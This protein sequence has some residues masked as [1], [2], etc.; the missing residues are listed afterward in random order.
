MLVVKIDTT[1]T[2]YSKLIKLE[3]SLSNT[4]KALEAKNSD[5]NHLMEK[6]DKLEKLVDGIQLLILF[7]SPSK[8]F[9]IMTLTQGGFLCSF[10]KAEGVC[11]PWLQAETKVVTIFGKFFFFLSF[12]AAI[13]NPKRGC[14]RV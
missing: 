2:T 13:K 8:L 14:R 12:S 10:V 9:Y 4:E 5:I 11:C 1:G 3:N 7:P 6:F